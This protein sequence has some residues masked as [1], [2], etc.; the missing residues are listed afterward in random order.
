MHYISQDGLGFA[1]GTNRYKALGGLAQ[2][3]LFLFHCMCAL[4]FQEGSPQ[5]CH[6]GTRLTEAPSPLPQCLWRAGEVVDCSRGLTNSVG[7]NIRLHAYISLAHKPA[8][9]H[10]TSGGQMNVVLLRAGDGDGGE[11]GYLMHGFGFIC[12]S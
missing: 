12:V 8:R 3:S 11:L 5:H 4:G 6:S 7:N 1:A 10:L 2:Q 9:P